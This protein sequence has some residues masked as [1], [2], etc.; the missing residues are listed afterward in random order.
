[1]LIPKEAKN[2]QI[3]SKEITSYDFMYFI[4]T[5]GKKDDCEMYEYCYRY[6]KEVMDDIKR[7]FEYETILKDEIKN[8]VLNKQDFPGDTD[9]N[10]SINIYFFGY[11]PSAWR[12]H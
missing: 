9:F 11:A 4:V 7:F 8:F 3:I 2:N 5:I 12:P 10:T 6:K 1:M